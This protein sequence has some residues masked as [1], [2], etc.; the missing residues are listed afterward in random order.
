MRRLLLL[1]VCFVFIVKLYETVRDDTKV[2]FDNANYKFFC[3]T[4]EIFKA[5]EVTPTPCGY[6]LLLENGKIAYVTGNVIITEE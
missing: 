6:K 4:L 2:A 3:R 1:C 5:T